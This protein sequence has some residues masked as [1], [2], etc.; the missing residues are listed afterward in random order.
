MI[1][2]YIPD[3][4]VDGINQTDGDNAEKD[5]DTLNEGKLDEE[6]EKNKFIKIRY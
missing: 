6:I 1:S 2:H 4:P 3:D 5:L